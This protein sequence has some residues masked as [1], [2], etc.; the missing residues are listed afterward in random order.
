[1][2]PVMKQTRAMDD[3]FAFGEKEQGHECPGPRDRE[4]GSTV[5]PWGGTAYP[6]PLPSPNIFGH[7][8]AGPQISVQFAPR[9]P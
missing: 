1:M 4:C 8:R 5:S 7:F 3:E 2:P 6:M 9:G